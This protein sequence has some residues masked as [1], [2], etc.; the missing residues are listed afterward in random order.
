MKNIN[1]EFDDTDYW[2]AI[3]LFGLNVATY[4]PALAKC[5]LEAAE[6]KKSTLEWDDL[7]LSFFN[8][9]LERLKFQSMPQQINPGRL[10]KLERIIKSYKL[11]QISKTEAVEQVGRE[12]FND[13]VKR[14]HTIGSNKNFADS[15]FYEFKFGKKLLLKDS[16]FNILEKDGKTLFGEIDSR[17][18]LLEGQFE[19]NH[20]NYDFKL[21]N[22]L[23]EIYIKNGYERKPLTHLIPFLNG[24][25][26][27]VCFYCGEE[28][29]NIH[30]D[31][32]LPRQVILNDEIWNLVLAHSECNEMKTDLIVSNHFINKLIIRNENIMGSNHPM[33]HQ[34]VKELGKT[35]RERSKNLQK[36]YEQ[37][38][39]IRGNSYWGGSQ[40]YNPEKDPF[41]RRLITRINGV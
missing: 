3:M 17:W 33:R 25:Q 16:L 29:A 8:A 28:M 10:T 21:A 6:Q 40:F 41:Y 35:K 11:K 15:Y 38:K 36:H 24:Y 27:N 2:Q 9:Y 7:S 4:K 1:K 23:R 34:I 20:T 12:G 22:D 18:G 5:I 13:V 37:V 30:V 31:H 14:F 19:M 32:V 26:G 39:T